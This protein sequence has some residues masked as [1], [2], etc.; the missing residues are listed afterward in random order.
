M[1]IKEEISKIY[2]KHE[3]AKAAIRREHEK[4]HKTLRDETHAAF[5]KVD[6]DRNDEV[7]KIL[8]PYPDKVSMIC[9]LL[10]ENAKIK[11]EI[12]ELTHPFPHN[13]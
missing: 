1:S 9:S 8:E 11:A 6:A 13:E 7:A 5:L 3:L 10:D 2:Y 4:R 12:Y